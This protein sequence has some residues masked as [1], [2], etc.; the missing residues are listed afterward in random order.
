MVAKKFVAAET[1]VILVKTAQEKEELYSCKV[2]KPNSYMV[3]YKSFVYSK[4]L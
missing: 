1:N 4:K 2:I 3:R